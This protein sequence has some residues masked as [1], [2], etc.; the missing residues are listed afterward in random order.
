MIRGPGDERGFGRALALRSGVSLLG[1]CC[2]AAGWARAQALVRARSAARS[3]IINTDMAV[4]EA[5]DV[6][7]DLPCTVTPDKP[8]LGFD[9]RFHAG[10]D[11]ASR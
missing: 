2:S 1:A 4:L 6:R 7:K 5:Q 8:V 10:Y 11:V 3:R 9:L